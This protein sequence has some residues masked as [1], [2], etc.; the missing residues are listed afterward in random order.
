LVKVS[1]DSGMMWDAVF[2]VQTEN[3][4][5]KHLVLRY[6]LAHQLLTANQVRNFFMM[7]GA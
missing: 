6:V 2:V 7:V 4:A 5:W 3:P 1:H